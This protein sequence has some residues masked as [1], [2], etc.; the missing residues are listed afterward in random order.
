MH[1]AN[2]VPMHFED[3]NYFQDDAMVKK[4]NGLMYPESDGMAPPAVVVSNY[5]IHRSLLCVSSVNQPSII[6]RLHGLNSIYI[7]LMRD[8]PGS[9]VS[10]CAACCCMN[11]DMSDSCSN[12]SD[13]FFRTSCFWEPKIGWKE[14]CSYDYYIF[15]FWGVTYCVIGFPAYERQIP[16]I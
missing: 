14:S 15:F 8:P 11:R 5:M 13:S 16:I 7:P 3:P 2:K 1:M 9:T 12:M 10:V 4:A 6:M